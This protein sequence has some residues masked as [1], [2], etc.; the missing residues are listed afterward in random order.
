MVGGAA[1]SGSSVG[2]RDRSN[3]LAWSS[4]GWEDG[5]A[6]QAEKL[7]ALQQGRVR[8]WAVEVLRVLRIA[9]RCRG[10]CL[11]R[12]GHSWRGRQARER[13]AWTGGS[14]RTPEAPHTSVWGCGLQPGVAGDPEK[15]VAGELRAELPFRMVSWHWPR[16]WIGG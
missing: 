10:T 11:P 7:Q 13:A 16:E 6:P 9:G 4:H 5:A 14:G 15:A 1:P 8:D 12:R 2:K 3:V